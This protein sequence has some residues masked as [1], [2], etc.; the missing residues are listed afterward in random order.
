MRCITYAGMNEGFY[1]GNCTFGYWDFLLLS[2]YLHSIEW[3]LHHAI[4]NLL[5]DLVPSG[6]R[7]LVALDYRNLTT[8]ESTLVSIHAGTHGCLRACS[9]LL[10]YDIPS[11]AR[12]TS[13]PVASH[14]VIIFTS[15]HLKLQRS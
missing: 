12:S 9:L 11:K 14:Q 7:L 3:F 13:F 8:R 5:S 10:S 15:F 6:C 4:L 2:T 1:L